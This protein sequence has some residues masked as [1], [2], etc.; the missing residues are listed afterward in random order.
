MTATIT[1]RA[2]RPRNKDLEEDFCDWVV[3]QRALDGKSQVELGLCGR[4]LTLAECVAIIGPVLDAVHAATLAG[5]R[6]L[7]AVDVLSGRMGWSGATTRRL[8]LEARPE[9]A[10]R[11]RKA[12]AG[13]RSWEM[14]ATNRSGPRPRRVQRRSAEAVERRQA[15]RAVNRASVAA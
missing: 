12:R 1:R 2:G 8:A 6:P 3:V 11:M 5:Y 10:E 4:T 9:H 15:T 7:L 14:I 13:Y